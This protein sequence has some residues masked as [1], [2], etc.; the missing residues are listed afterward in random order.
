MYDTQAGAA[1]GGAAVSTTASEP[2]PAFDTLGDSCPD[3]IFEGAMPDQRDPALPH[4]IQVHHIA[5]MCP[6]F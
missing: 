3:E 1:E 5:F 4:L 6:A 2:T